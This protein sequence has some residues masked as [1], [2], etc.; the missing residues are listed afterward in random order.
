MKYSMLHRSNNS[1]FQTD[2]SKV[3]FAI[4]Y[5]REEK[6]SWAVIVDC[7]TGNIV[8]LFNLTNV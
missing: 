7:E 6:A 1:N 5:Y 8:H 3:K 4:D 2:W